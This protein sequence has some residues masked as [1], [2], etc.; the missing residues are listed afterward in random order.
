MNINRNKFQSLIRPI[1]IFIGV[2]GLLLLSYGTVAAVRYNI[3]LNETIPTVDDWLGIPV[4]VTDDLGDVPTAD[5]DIINAWVATSDTGS[6]VN[7]NFLVQVN[8]SL[9]VN[10]AERG[11]AAYIDC[12]DPDG[13]P[14]NGVMEVWDRVLVY[15]KDNAQAG[16]EATILFFG[17]LSQLYPFPD[18]AEFGQIVDGYV[19]WGVPIAELPPDP[20]G[21]QSN[22]RI[23]DSIPANI[24]LATVNINSQENIDTT[25]WGGFDIATAVTMEDM[26]AKSSAWNA[27]LAYVALGGVLVLTGF[28]GLAIYTKKKN[29]Q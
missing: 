16:G 17:D 12:E 8:A 15:D 21:H 7:L 26:N 29:S 25:V 20:G 10:G 9:A 4:F 27:D 11:V 2:V 22:C 13:N 5:E 1:F 23:G 19:E 18:N 6:P 24:Y 28:G 3:D 14:P